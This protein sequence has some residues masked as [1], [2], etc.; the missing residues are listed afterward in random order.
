[1][2]TAASALAALDPSGGGANLAIGDLYAKTNVAND[3][4]PMANFTLFRRQASGATT[5]TS[6]AITA[7]SPGAG[8]STFTIASTNK[9]S[10]NFSAATTVS[11]TTTGSASG[12]ANLIAA[13]ITSAGV[14]N[15]SA[16]VD[17]SN[18]IVITHS[19]GGEIKFVDTDGLLT[20]IG[21]VPFNSAV[22]TTTPNLAYV[23]GTGASTNPKQL[24]ATNWRVLNY[25]ASADAVT[26]L[27][28]QGQLWYN[29]IVDEVDML[30]HNGTTWVGYADSTAY[31]NADPNG[32]IVSAS[33]PTQQSDGG[34]L[35]TG[36]LW[37]ST[38]DLENYPTVYRYNVDISGTTAQKWGS[39]LDASDQTTENGILF[40]D[41][42]YGTGPG[43]T[44]VAPSGTIPEMLASNYLDPDAPDPALY[45]KGMLLWNLT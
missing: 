40:A 33:M 39:P 28:S 2:Q 13:A 36:D 41:A 45:P 35:V 32:P 5:I 16:S 9:G 29:S 12:D 1:M 6:A 25:T 20:S 11:V 15:V 19:Q 31:P 18:K 44:T 43:T 7:A 26:S 21:F 10:A 38:A 4:L 42:R 3:T 22:P 14:A 30:W 27:A 24:Q 34:S 17:A 23:D 37:I 8:T